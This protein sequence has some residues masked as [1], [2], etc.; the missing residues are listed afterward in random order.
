[1]TD[2]LIKKKNKNRRDLFNW[3]HV[4]SVRGKGFIQK[5]ALIK[6]VSMEKD[7]ILFMC[8][9]TQKAHCCRIRN[10]KQKKKIQNSL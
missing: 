5:L 8:H 10:L 3:Q 1:M 7:E 4:K 9:V 2:K 6:S